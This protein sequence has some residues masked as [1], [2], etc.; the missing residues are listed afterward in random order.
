MALLLFQDPSG[1]GAQVIENGAPKAD[2]IKITST[3]VMNPPNANGG[4]PKFNWVQP[5]WLHA[6]ILISTTY[7]S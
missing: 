5:V 2:M 7:C 3:P 4:V 6:G 1:L